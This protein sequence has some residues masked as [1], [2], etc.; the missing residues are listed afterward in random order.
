MKA[1]KIKKRIKGGY[2]ALISVII[3]CAVLLMVVITTAYIGMTQGIDS[4]IYS[5]SIS[6]E[7]LASACAEDALMNLKNNQN[8]AGNQTLDLSTGQCQILAITSLNNVKTVE[9]SSSVN[10]ATKKIKITVSQ[11]NPTMTVSSW[12][13]VADF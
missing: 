9:T 6:A 2:V 5:N 3:I 7:N 1:E 13:E 12:Q 8:Y 10:S 4:L 11:I